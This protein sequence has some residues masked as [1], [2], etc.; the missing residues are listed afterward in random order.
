[1]RTSR[2]SGLRVRDTDRVDA[3]ALLDAARDNGQ[4]TANEHDDRTVKAMRAK[5][6]GDLDGLIGDLQVP[7][8]L[9]D[10]PVVRTD[11][12]RRSR[13]WEVAAAV[14]GAAGILGALVG[15]GARETVGRPMP[16]LNTGRGLDA[17][18]A[19]YRERYGDTMVDELTLYPDYVII[20]RQS[21]TQTQ[22]I[23]YDGGFNAY[24]ESSRSDKAEAFDL[25]TI[26]VPVIARFIAGAPKSV[27]A[28]GSPVGHIMIERPEKGENPF[29]RIYVESPG[30]TG[31]LEVTT[32]GEPLRVNRVDE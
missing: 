18:I 14:V 26:D 6:F 16:D 17:L 13:R 7:A 19:D 28:P 12:R 23:R 9:V 30:K 20:E 10:T 32:A 5:T 8:N 11:R 3:C 25:A 15:W 2:H 24:T 31:Y 21:G 29:V 27:R 22:R 4:L 1:M